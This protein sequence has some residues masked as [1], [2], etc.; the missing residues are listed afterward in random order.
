MKMYLNTEQT[1]KLIELGFK[2]N[3]C[4]I[5]EKTEWSYEWRKETFTIGHLIEMLPTRLIVDGIPCNRVIDVNEVLYYNIVLDFIGY[6]CNDNTYLL[7]N[8]YDMIVKLKEEGV[9]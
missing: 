5:E 7:D 9:I 1:A 2:H 4:E 8:L 6:L 3:K